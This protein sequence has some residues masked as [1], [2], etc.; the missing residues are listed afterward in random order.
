MPFRGPE[1]CQCTISQRLGRLFSKFLRLTP[2]PHVN[3]SEMPLVAG[4]LKAYEIRV[5]RSKYSACKS[6][7]P[8]KTPRKHE[9]LGHGLIFN[10]KSSLIVTKLKGFF[11]KHDYS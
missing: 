4:T 1:S 6:F 10:T 2:V 8:V 5:L 7:R 11:T 3:H 9:Q